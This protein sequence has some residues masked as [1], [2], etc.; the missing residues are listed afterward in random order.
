VGLDLRYTEGQPPL[1][2]EELDELRVK[3]ISARGELDELEQQNIEKAQEW[4]LGRNLSADRILSAEFVFE[5]HERMFGDVWSWAGQQRRTNKNIGVDWTLI[6]TELR[7]LIDGTKY[8]IA[9]HT[10][11]EDEIAIRFKHTLVSIHCF[12]NGNGRHSRLMADVIVDK[13]FD[14]PLFTWGRGNITQ[15]GLTRSQYLA[16]LRSADQATVVDLI[17]FARS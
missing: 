13:I 12:P 11:P 5:L 17:A 14:R 10:Y 16:A 4:V 8:W 7:S 9:H 3:S 6:R 1:T 2:P 15:Q